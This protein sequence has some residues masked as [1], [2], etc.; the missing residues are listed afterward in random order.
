MEVAEFQKRLEQICQ[1]AKSAGNQLSQA[2]ILTAFEGLPLTPEQLGKV[3][4]YL[5]IQGIEIE[6]TTEADNGA[7][8]TDGNMNNVSSG[9]YA[10]HTDG[11]T[12]GSPQKDRNDAS[13]KNDAS[14]EKTASPGTPLPLTPEQKAWLKEY[15]AELSAQTADA[16]TENAGTSPQTVSGAD[17]L[18]SLF[19]RHSH[20]DAL[21]MA[22]LSQLYLPAAAQLAAEMNC[23]EIA[24]S[25]LIQEANVSLLT[26][27]SEPEPTVKSDLWLRQEIRR[28]IAEAIEEQTQQKFRDDCLVAKVEKLEAA[29]RDLT[30]EDG[31]NRFSI[32]ELAVILDMKTDEIRDI[33]KLTG[34]DK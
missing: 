4:T 12:S 24:L 9:E 18:A 19:E 17:R 7:A 20:G 16:N 11:S 21:A 33:L 14:A 32:D 10:D 5:K 15:L 2:Q 31:E 13:E 8:R 28:G 27:L 34:D 25:D 22:E 23:A 29:V 1:M 3:L 26:A 6:G 30:D